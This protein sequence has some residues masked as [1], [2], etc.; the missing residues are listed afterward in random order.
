M[1]VRKEINL[2]KIKEKCLTDPDNP[3]F[4]K[5]SEFIGYICDASLFLTN[6]DPLPHFCKY[7]GQTYIPKDEDYGFFTCEYRCSQKQL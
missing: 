4:K 3:E 5:K 1:A 6:L 7:Q 2:K